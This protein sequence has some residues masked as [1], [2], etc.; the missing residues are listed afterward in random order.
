MINASQFLE[1]SEEK[2]ST[3]FIDLDES[4]DGL[5]YSNG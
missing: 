2:I 5:G 4:I 1:K 3:G